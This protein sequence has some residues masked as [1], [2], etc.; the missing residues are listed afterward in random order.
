MNSTLCCGCGF[1]AASQRL[2]CGGAEFP[3]VNVQ[4][5]TELY[6]RIGTKG[7]SRAGSCRKL[8]GKGWARNAAEERHDQTKEGTGNNKKRH[9][10]KRKEETR[11]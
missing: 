10:K 3:A 6:Y 11:R 8:N 2:I 5:K 1:E 9:K 4:A 7:G